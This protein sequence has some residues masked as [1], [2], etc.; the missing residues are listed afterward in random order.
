MKPRTRPCKNSA[1]GWGWPSPCHTLWRA[2]AALGLE[3]K[4]KKSSAA[5]EQDR[6]DVAD[7]RQQFRDARLGLEPDHRL[8]FL[9]ET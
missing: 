5:A 8:V 7:K 6:P 4:K 9:D 3:R 1:T 2:V